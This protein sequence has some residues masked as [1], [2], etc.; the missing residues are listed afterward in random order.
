MARYDL[1]RGWFRT[2]RGAPA[3]VYLREGT[4]DFNT[5]Q[6]CLTEDEYG[7]RDRHITGLALDIGGYLGTVAIAVLADNPTARVIC[8]EPVPEN[9]D[10]IERNARANGVSERL[11]LVR[12]A[13]G[14]AGESIT[15]RYAYQGGEN[16][17]HH[18]Y[19]GNSTITAPEAE[20]SAITYPATTL[21]DLTAEED[22]TWCK[23]DC[24]GG[25][26]AALDDPGVARSAHITG[27]WH[28]VPFPDGTTGS[29]AHIRA[30]LEPTH[31][32]TFTGPV[33]GPGGFT[34]VRR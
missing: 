4:N 33:D 27:E 26:Y 22:A 29:Q 30:L 1:Y 15:V 6:S 23:I 24:E 19:V 25:E 12:G 32:V 21:S 3:V 7:L 16:E 28:N 2:P 34:A 9:A 17:L 13:M 10:L 5:A 11:T 14:R 31:D 20:H 18:A 8:V